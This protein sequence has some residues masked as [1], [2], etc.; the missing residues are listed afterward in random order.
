MQL[1]CNSESGVKIEPLA[2]KKENVCLPL[3][4]QW[5]SR[6]NCLT[7]DQK[8]SVLLRKFNIQIP[9]SKTTHHILKKRYTYMIQ[10]IFQ[11]Q[12]FLF[13]EISNRTH[14][15]RK[16]WTPKPEYLIAQFATYWTG[17]VGFKV[18][19][20]FLMDLEKQKNRSIFQGCEFSQLPSTFHLRNSP[21]L[22]LQPP[23]RWID[24]FWQWSDKRCNCAE[25]TNRRFFNRFII[26]SI[27]GWGPPCRDSWLDWIVT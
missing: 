6:A 18:P 24:R 5:L 22:R 9:K 3:P 17:S 8:R 11:S 1:G 20:N 12:S 23:A 26:R 13:Q 2:P 4:L 19:F 10:Y 16:T 25:L 27:S 14:W 21:Q 7:D 15:S